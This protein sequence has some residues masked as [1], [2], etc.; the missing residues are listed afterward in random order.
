MG[1]RSNCLLNTPVY[2]V[3][4]LSTSLKSRTFSAKSLVANKNLPNN[5]RVLGNYKTTP[6]SMGLLD[7]VYQFDGKPVPKMPH[8]ITLQHLKKV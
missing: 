7:N 6:N 2:G 4:G 3:A 1:G 5:Y 8:N